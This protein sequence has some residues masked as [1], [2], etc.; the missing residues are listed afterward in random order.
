MT[1]RKCTLRRVLAVAVGAVLAKEAALEVVQAPAREVIIPRVVGLP[2][3]RAT[4]PAELPTVGVEREMGRAPA[5]IVA[6]SVSAS[7]KR[8]SP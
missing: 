8:Q 2:H 4:H 7:W 1:H 5:L 6:V 3:H